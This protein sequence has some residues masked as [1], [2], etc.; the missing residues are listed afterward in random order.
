M[1]KYFLPITKIALVLVYLVIVAGALV[2]MTGSGMG[3]P[4]WP[5]CFG[6]YIPPTDEK[7]LLFTPNRVYK[8]G[9]VIIKEETLLVAKTDFT[10]TATFS[11]EDWEQYTKHDY[12][13]FN[14]S[15]TWVEY[16]NR[17]FGALAG[18]ACFA[19]FIVSFWFWKTNKKLVLYTF[20]ICFLMGFQAWLGKTVVDSVLNPVKI[21]THMLAAFLIVGLQL[22]LIFYFQKSQTK[23]YNYHSKFKSAI[24]VTLV[25]TLVQVVLGTAV[26][27][28][29][30]TISETG[31]PKETWLQS[32]TLSFYIHRSFSILVTLAIAYLVYLNSKLKLGY[33]KI[34][35]VVALVVF[36]I[37]SGIAMYYF[38]FPFGSQTLHIVLSSLLFGFL[39]YLVL[40]S[41]QSRK[42][43]S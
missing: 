21:T 9:M 5:K 23:G 25:L 6:Y 27:E 11:K 34:K 36:E 39:F 2:R 20:I 13:I 17:L 16:I 30:D 31:L 40:E 4:D 22:Y 43:L 14:P 19:S 42:Q 3:C 37:L 12:A 35:F 33:T 41:F 18:I 29:V 10:T 8:K 15:H 28:H 7:E 24:I 32:P 1:K 38:Y 26:R